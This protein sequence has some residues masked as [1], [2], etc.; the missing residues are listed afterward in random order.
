MTFPPRPYLHPA[1]SVDT[2]QEFTGEP[3]AIE[4]LVHAYYADV[5]RLAVSILEEVEDAEEVAQDT[6]IAA[7]AGL[8][9]FRGD[10]KLKTWLFGIAINLCRTRLRKRRSRMVLQH[11]L[12]AL[13]FLR[14]SQPSPEEIVEH[15]E[16]HTRLWDAIHALDEKHRLPVIL[17]YLHELSVPE[18]SEILT[19]EPGTVYSRL[20]YARKKLHFLLKHSP[21]PSP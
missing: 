14:P 1:L 4:A 2:L 11:A 18:I 19:L 20:H 13:H 10:S 17:H 21:P 6:F 7:A 15:A 3:S 5:Y 12:E 9:R 16:L 8:E